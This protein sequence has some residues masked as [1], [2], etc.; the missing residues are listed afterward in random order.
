MTVLQGAGARWGVGGGRRGTV[1]VVEGMG[2]A[3]GREER[4]S[5][6]HEVA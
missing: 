4:P 3:A 2:M 6:K 1:K 5:G